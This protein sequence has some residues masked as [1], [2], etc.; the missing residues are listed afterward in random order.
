M[1]VTVSAIAQ[2]AETRRSGVYLG[3][4][5]SGWERLVRYC[6]RRGTL[7]TLRELDDRVLQDIG[8]ER[9]QIEAAARD[10]TITPN[11]IRP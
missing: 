6:V 8:V 3:T 4:L 9:S 10:F 1:S 5:S 11:W 7:A 2:P